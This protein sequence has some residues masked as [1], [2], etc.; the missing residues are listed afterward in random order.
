MFNIEWIW[1]IKVILQFLIYTLQLIL[2][3]YVI[4]KITTLVYLLILPLLV[5]HYPGSIWIIIL[6][7]QR[8]EGLTSSLATW[9]D[10]I[11]P[12]PR[13]GIYKNIKLSH[14]C[15]Y[16]GVLSSMSLLI[17]IERIWYFRRMYIRV[18]KRHKPVVSKSALSHLNFEST[19]LMDRLQYWWFVMCF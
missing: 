11:N 8:R 7:R 1:I 18:S 14:A 13:Y 15:F 2:L 4:L 19:W 9:K 5:E 16:I 6:K 10:T 17:T 12:F 3:K